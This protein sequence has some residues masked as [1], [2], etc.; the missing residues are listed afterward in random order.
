MEDSDY[1]WSLKL[2]G[3]RICVGV[4]DGDAYAQNRH[5]SW[6]K[7]TIDNLKTY[8]S[9]KG[10]WLL[11]GEV[12]N[13]QFYPFEVVVAASKSVAA[14]CPQERKDYAKQLCRRLGVPWMYGIDIKDIVS[15]SER[16]IPLADGKI[17][18]GVVGKQKSSPY[19]PLGTVSGASPAWIKHKWVG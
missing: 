14:L 13:K 7:M 10:A 3:D 15:Q 18:E 1:D 19:V 5:G 12:F 16:L 9:L 17:Y 2:N 4:V 8:A 6:Y 11:D